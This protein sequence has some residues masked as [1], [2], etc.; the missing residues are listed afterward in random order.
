MYTRKE[1][2]VQ[3]KAWTYS[4]E[5]APEKCLRCIDEGGEDW[6]CP[7][8]DVRECDLADA[9]DAAWERTR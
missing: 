5:D 9:Y 8:F 6:F 1:G 3:T 2:T 7:F 4:Y